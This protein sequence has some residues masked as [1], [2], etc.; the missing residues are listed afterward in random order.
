MGEMPAE[1]KDAEDI[2]GVLDGAKG[3]CGGKPGEKV[4][5]KQCLHEPHLAAPGTALETDPW[6]VRLDFWELRDHTRC[7]VFAF[8]F[9]VNHVPGGLAGGGLLFGHWAKVVGCGK[10]ALWPS[11][12]GEQ[13]LNRST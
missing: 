7:Q 3:R 8:G 4:A 2:L 1:F 6:A 10:G 9:G 11:N 12:E 13:L 5:G